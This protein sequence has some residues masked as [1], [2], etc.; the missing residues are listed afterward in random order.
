M[1]FYLANR[2]HLNPSAGMH[3]RTPSVQAVDLA[4]RP[5]QAHLTKCALPSAG[6]Q[7][8]GNHIRFD[9]PRP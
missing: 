5:Y 6:P 1:Q 8:L 4:L 3:A 7:S 9:E 2:L